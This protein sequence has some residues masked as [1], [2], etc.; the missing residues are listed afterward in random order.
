MNVKAV[1]VA[2]GYGTRFLP[3]SRVVP[4]E[5]LPIGGRPGIDLV[6]DELRDAGIRD[7][8]IITSR[9]KRSIE[10]WFD[11]DPELE[12]ALG[13]QRVAPPDIRAT[14]VRQAQMTG[15]GHALLL[16]RAF[17]G[18]DPVIVV[19]PDDLFVGANPTAELI[20]AW[21]ATGRSA[22][23]ARDLPGTDVSRYGVLDLESG[24]GSVRR[25]RRLIEKPP[26]G[27]EPST[28]V[29]LGRYLLLPEVFDALEAGAKAHEG[30]EYYHVPAI[31]LLAEKGA[32]VAVASAAS[33][34]DTGTPEGWI[35]ACVQAEIRRDPTFLTWLKAETA[36]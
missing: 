18:N 33:Y 19:Y 31:N 17:A 24:S 11:R 7:V 13:A 35:R 34:L 21:V 28:W 20:A 3:G 6:I 15:T 29:S 12:M 30:G 5:L 26:K 2:A 22:L 36:P 9:R 27:T 1:I 23:L 32:V 4:K 8:L 14:F 10:D 25:V 16:A